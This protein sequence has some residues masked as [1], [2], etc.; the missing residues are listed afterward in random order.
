METVIKFKGK[1]IELRQNPYIT[2][3]SL[4]PHE[5]PYYEAYGTDEEGND[6]IVKWVVLDVF[7][8][9]NNRLKELD[10][11]DESEMCDWD[12]PSTLYIL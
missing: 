7:L 8:D 9:E 6:V 10:Y 1:D 2:A 3:T 5:K 12:N 11:V 4:K